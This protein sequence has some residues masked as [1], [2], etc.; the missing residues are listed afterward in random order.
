VLDVLAIAGGFGQFAS[1]SRIFVLRPETSKMKRIP[2]NYNKA[3][4]EGGEQE[5][6]YLQP[7]DIV[8]V[9]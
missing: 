7:N 9:P 1:R 5:N 4:T 6:F 8:V 2:F 3:V